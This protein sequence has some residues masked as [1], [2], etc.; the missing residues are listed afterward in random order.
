[1]TNA[2]TILNAVGV[3]TTSNIITSDIIYTWPTQRFPGEVLLADRPDLRIP[4]L[5]KTAAFRGSSGR[6]ADEQP[7]ISSEL[8]VH[9]R[10]IL[11][12]FAHRQISS[13]E[14]AQAVGAFSFVEPLAI[15]AI[16]AGADG[17]ELRLNKAL[18]VVDIGGGGHT[19]EFLRPFLGTARYL[20]FD[21]TPR[22]IKENKL[23]SGTY[24]EHY[25]MVNAIVT[26]PGLAELLRTHGVPA[27]PAVLKIDIDSCDCDVLEQALKHFSPSVVVIEFNPAFPPP[28][29]FNLAYQ[30]KMA[31]NDRGAPSPIFGCSLSY[32]A[33]VAQRFGYALLQ[34]P[35]EDAYFVHASRL[36]LFGS[37]PREEQL[38][39]AMG[40]PLGYVY[41]DFGAGVLS[42]WSAWRG[43]QQLLLR[44]VHSNVSHRIRTANLMQMSEQ[45]HLSVEPW[46][47]IGGPQQ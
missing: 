24:F 41:R 29:R 8:K 47:E 28:I 9:Y 42:E 25:D 40:N 39:Y 11:R 17:H 3:A 37:I 32:A 13:S 5:N 6:L 46:K 33:D 23:T 14:F 18:C 45:V 30:P 21:A 10:R 22:S 2:A 43:E 12:E 35:I 15:L 4:A 26:P 44:V 34:A 20:A 1:M 7:R 38:V 31:H 19:P 16:L 27:A 36:P